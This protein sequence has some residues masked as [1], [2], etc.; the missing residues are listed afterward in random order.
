MRQCYILY[1]VTHPEQCNTSFK[2]QLAHMQCAE[3]A[4]VSQPG[5]LALTQ[6]QTAQS[7]T[8]ASIVSTAATGCLV[9]A[10]LMLGQSCRVGWGPNGTLFMPGGS[11]TLQDLFLTLCEASQLH[12]SLQ[13]LEALRWHAHCCLC[14]RATDLPKQTLLFGQ[15]ITLLSHIVCRLISC[16]DCACCAVYFTTTLI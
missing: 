1:W 4:I 2:C 9:D 8:V 6:R 7:S 15:Q 12:S 13:T 16:F 3:E 14:S 10:G 5:A 11:P